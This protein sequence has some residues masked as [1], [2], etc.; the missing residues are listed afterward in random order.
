MGDDT[1]NAVLIEC[2]KSAGG[3]KVVAGRLWPEKGIEQAQRRLLDCLNDDRPDRLC[4][5]QVLL[6]AELARAAGCHAYMAH[7]AQRLHYA[8]P[9]PREPRDELASLQREFVA[10]VAAQQRMVAQ[11]QQIADLAA[12][13]GL[14]A[15]A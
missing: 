8:M 10:A 6:I 11:M 1:L 4:P 14:K 7:C 2:V 13:A 12:P 3:S 15:V 5:D 9:V